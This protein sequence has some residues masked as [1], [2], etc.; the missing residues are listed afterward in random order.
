[1]CRSSTS[2]GQPATV[3]SASRRLKGAPTGQ[4][5]LAIALSSDMLLMLCVAGAMAASALRHGRLTDTLCPWP[6]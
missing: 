5:Q 4:R 2:D 1:M 6:A 3:F